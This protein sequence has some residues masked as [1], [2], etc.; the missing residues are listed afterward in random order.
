MKQLSILHHHANGEDDGMSTSPSAG[1]MTT[2]LPRSVHS[3]SDPSSPRSLKPAHVTATGENEGGRLI[4]NNNVAAQVDA[5]ADRLSRLLTL[6]VPG[7]HS[8]G[9]SRKAKEGFDATS[10]DVDPE[11]LLFGNSNR[12]SRDYSG[13]GEKS[14]DAAVAAP[15]SPRGSKSVPSD[16]GNEMFIALPAVAAAAR[17]VTCQR[18]FDH[19]DNV[20]NPPN[21]EETD[22]VQGS[23]QATRDELTR[24]K[25]ELVEARREIS[26]LGVTVA[27]LTGNPEITEST[28]SF[29][30]Y[31][32]FRRHDSRTSIA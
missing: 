14:E 22:N 8:T 32:R 5:V 15:K 3:P 10:R 21:M 9:A 28:D 27:A 24:V 18:H 25:V 1:P 19:V 2:P 31:L 26:N 29:D 13:P 23:A 20:A 17:T 7:H 30:R 4:R 12:S 6:P 16:V 11:S